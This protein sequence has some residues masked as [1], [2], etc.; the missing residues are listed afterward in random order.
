MRKFTFSRKERLHLKREFEKV[1][2]EG[3]KISHRDFD[4]FFI[5]NSLGFPRIG[6]SISRKCGK[7]VDRNR[8]K[9][10]IR[11]AFRLNKYR[12]PPVD[13]VL[14][15]RG[16]ADRRMKFKEIEEPF[17]EIVGKIGD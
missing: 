16:K 11:E 10:L 2:E 13:M 17:L 3:R 7:A 12:I 6:I 15:Y 1:I 8:V 14:I 9:R 5:K 4:V